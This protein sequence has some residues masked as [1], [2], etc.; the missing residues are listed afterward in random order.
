VRSLVRS[1]F[2]LL[3]LVSGLGLAMVPAH[4]TVSTSP[5][6]TWGT[7]G[8]VSAIVRADGMIY[9]GGE[10]TALQSD[11]GQLVARNHLAALD[12]S[13]GQPT[14]WDPNANGNVL[15][16]SLSPDGTRLYVGGSFGKIGAVTRKK[17]AAFDLPSGN[18][19]SWRPVGWPNNSVRAI[20]VTSD[21][22]YTGG[23]F[24]TIGGVGRSRLA[25]LSPSTGDLLPWAPVADG[26][27]RDIELA[28][29]KIW[30][31]GNFAT[32]NGAAQQRLTLVDPV[33]GA[34]IP[35]SYHPGYPV[36]ELEPGAA[37]MYA[38]GGGGGGKALALNLSTGAKIWEKKTDGNVQGVGVFGGI[39]YFG[40]HFFTYTGV[41]V[42]QLVRADPATGNLD[43]SWLP[44]VTAGFLGVFT[45]ASSGNHLYVGGD[46]T[47]V[48]GQKQLN[49]AQFTDDQVAAQA[50]LGVTLTDAPDPVDVGASLAYTAHVANAGPDGATSVLLTDPLPVGMTFLSAS[51]GCTYDGG[52]KTV[53]CDLGSIG[54]SATANATITVQPGASGT[55]SN[56]VTVSSDA[57]DS[58]PANDHAT[59]TTTVNAVP[60]ADLGVSATPGSGQKLDQ[61]AAFDYVLSVSNQGPDP[62][63]AAAAT[64]AL[65]AGMSRNGAVTTT[66]GSCSGTTSISCSLGSL[67][68]NATAT[69]TIPVV[70]PSTP[71]T[72]VNVAK[73]SGSGFDPDPSDDSATSYTNVRDPASSGDTTAPSRTST[74]MFDQNAD[75]FVDRVVVTF[76]E[77]LATCSAPCTAG[78]ALA[79][80]PSGGSLQSVTTSGNQ[81]I[82]TIG[83][84]QDLQSTAVGSFKVTL[85]GPNQI[86]D[87]AGN[88]ATFGATVPAD[89]AGPVVVGFRHQHNSSASQCK[90]L[91]TNAG[92]AQPCDELTAEWSE[93]LAPGSIPGT[94]PVTITDPSGSGNDRLTIPNFIQGAMD[95]G[96][97]AYLSLDGGSA[98]WAGSELLLTGAAQ[99]TLT[100]RLY[101]PCTGSGCSALSAASSVTVTY[102]PSGLIQDAVGNVAAGSFVK[103]QRMF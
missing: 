93:S 23:Q 76:N 4:A 69:I 7:N 16:L 49:F 36:L 83:N 43:T 94:T 65:P 42:N 25:A 48:S 88:R 96:S 3:F 38:A 29:G 40:G 82:L 19:G 63:P 37:R 1:S 26:N 53:T 90:G 68:V 60:G 47:R 9:L 50:D 73:V 64:D 70:A 103:Q 101:G 72:I 6:D 99:D 22:V 79:S 74:Q 21:T 31:G 5:D 13:T 12:A 45:V 92:I 33:S 75:G 32:V 51:P 41:A 18:L 54:P 58:H 95:L 98:T 102:M 14:S 57:S 35:G 28:A 27:V 100:I 97:N 24:T 15:R 87:A 39:P 34:T 46:F 80:V 81:A 62:E 61:G 91:V 52:S 30:L 20:E 11:S 8:R 59:A 77:A 71:Q 44:A 55:A 86:Q 56:T 10:F 85:N 67:G 89:K 17:I 84:W 78:W 2:V 66:Q